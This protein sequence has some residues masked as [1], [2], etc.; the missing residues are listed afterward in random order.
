MEA[1]TRHDQGRYSDRI[2]RID[3]IN[4]NIPNE[5]SAVVKGDEL[6]LKRRKTI[7]DILDEDAVATVTRSEL[8]KERSLLEKK[9]MDRLI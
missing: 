4:L 2:Y 9:L 3:R 6:L 7:S 1:D 8:R 5:F